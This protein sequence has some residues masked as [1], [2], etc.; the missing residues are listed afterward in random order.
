MLA[1]RLRIGEWTQRAAYD[2][3]RFPVDQQVL[4]IKNIFSDTL[5]F[6]G[7]QLAPYIKDARLRR[8]LLETIDSLS[9]GREVHEAPAN[10]LGQ[11]LP[12]QWGAYEPAWVIAQMVLKQ[13]ARFGHRPNPHGMSLVIEPWVL[14]ETLLERVLAQLARELSAHGHNAISR[15]QRRTRFLIGSMKAVEERYLLPDCVLSLDDKPIANFEAKYRDYSRTGSPLR[16]ESYQ[17][18]TAGRA[19][20]TELAVLVYPNAME[21]QVFGVEVSGHPPEKLAAIGLDLF[22]YR[23]GAGE[24]ERAAKV[25]SLLENATGTS[26]LMAKGAA[27]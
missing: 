4:S 1:G 14:L 21:A 27:A 3:H 2:G 8:Q 26:M 24:R 6:V 25:S 22:S 9:G 15:P 16:G 20:R 19:L 5:H 12:Q 18:I 11:E 10:A 13:Q 7:R 17:A 23:K